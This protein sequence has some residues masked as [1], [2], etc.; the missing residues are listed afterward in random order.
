MTAVG[1]PLT[2]ATSATASGASTPS[3]LLRPSSRD[4]SSQR[5]EV[6]DQIRLLV[7]S[8]AQSLPGVVRLDDGLQRR[9]RTVVEIGRVLPYAVK[10][11]RAVH[12]GRAARGV[13][14]RAVR[15][16]LADD[17]AGRVEPF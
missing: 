7:G 16:G 14:G 11:R 12:L 6:L 9:G 13:A 17:L 2:A 15:L 5:L 4:R 8:Q 10:R 3:A 1:N